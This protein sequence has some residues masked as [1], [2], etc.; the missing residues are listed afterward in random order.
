M[1]LNDRQIVEAYKRGDIVIE[2]FSEEQVQAATYDLRVGEQAA[3]TSSKKVVNVRD[4]GYVLLN[5]GDF[6]VVTVLEIIRL[7]PQ[8]TARFGLRSKFA[9][10]GLNRHDRTTD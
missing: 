5:P 2:P 1:I 3:T 7:G 10:K 4:A 6:A 8:Y 9:R